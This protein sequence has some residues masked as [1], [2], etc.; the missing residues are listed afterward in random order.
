MCV[1]YPPDPSSPGG[2]NKTPLISK[3]EILRRNTVWGI[4]P[5]RDG[6][7]CNGCHNRHAHINA[8][9][10]QRPYTAWASL[11]FKPL[12]CPV[13]NRTKSQNPIKY[14]SKTLVYA[15]FDSMRGM[16]NVNRWVFSYLSDKCT[17]MTPK[18]EHFLVSRRHLSDT[19]PHYHSASN[20]EWS[21]PSIC[22][23]GFSLCFHGPF[24]QWKSPKPAQAV[25]ALLIQCI[26]SVWP[27]LLSEP[28]SATLVSREEKRGSS[29]SRP[30]II[31]VL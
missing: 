22:R 14:K 9:P 30:V 16:W 5:S 8:K 27:G 18:R 21:R 19:T 29:Y 4:P 31:I 15:W 1:C 20:R 6:Q 13:D 28:L 10:H 3:E 7:E 26:I 2:K 17:D 23:H 12:S 24:R 11:P 25:R